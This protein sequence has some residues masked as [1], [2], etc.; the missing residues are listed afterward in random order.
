MCIHDFLRTRGIW[1]EAL[2]HQPASSSAKRAKNARV[3]GRR[4]AKA[5][6]IRVQE[7]FVLAVLPASS[8]IDLEQ[9]SQVLGM[10]SGEIRLATSDELVTMFSDC[11]PGVVPP[12]GRLYGLPTVVDS[13]LSEIGDI[14]V[15]ANT[16]HEGLWMHFRDFAAIEQPQQA[17]FSRPIAAGLKPASPNGREENRR[18]G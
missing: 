9:L 5:V 7:S 12:F 11:E 6:L 4:V 13:V 17:S 3:A 10:P 16:R 18:A 14:V 1:F 8:R 2:L 15:S